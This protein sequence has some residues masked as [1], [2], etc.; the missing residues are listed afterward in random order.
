MNLQTLDASVL[1]VAVIGSCASTCI[2]L[3]LGMLIVMS[4][5]ILD[6]LAIVF[7]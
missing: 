1:L 2:V 4:A 7:Y 3:V 5:S 6:P